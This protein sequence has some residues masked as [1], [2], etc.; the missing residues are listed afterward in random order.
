MTK[1]IL[2]VDRQLC[3]WSCVFSS[4][5]DRQPSSSFQHFFLFF[6]SQFEGW[7]RWHVLIIVIKHI[8]TV[9]FC[10]VAVWRYT[11]S[12]EGVAYRFEFILKFIS[13]DRI[14]LLAIDVVDWR[15]VHT[16]ATPTT[17]RKILF[18]RSIFRHWCVARQM[19]DED[20]DCQWVFHLSIYS[21]SR[22][23]LMLFFFVR[24]R[25]KTTNKSR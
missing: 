4:H 3:V 13:F 21:C 8:F 5:S 2:P 14:S 24:L 18:F 1:R 9:V 11:K 16:H 7:A 23:A 10:L 25:Y 17:V 20:I 12:V 19:I 15:F 6:S 22:S